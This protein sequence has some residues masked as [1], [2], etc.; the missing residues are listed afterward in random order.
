MAIDKVVMYQNTSV[1]NDEILSHR[2]GLIPVVANP[3]D[4]TFKDRN[5]ISQRR[6]R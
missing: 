5:I 2:L 3:D 1:L 4:F 6:L